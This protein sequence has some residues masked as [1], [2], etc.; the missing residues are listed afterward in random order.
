MV[1]HIGEFETEALL[2]RFIRDKPNV[3]FFRVPHE[4]Q[5]YFRTKKIDSFSNQIE[6]PSTRYKLLLTKIPDTISHPIVYG[7]IDMESSDYYDKRDTLQQNHNIKMKFYF[8]SQYR[9]Y[10]Y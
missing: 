4:G 8:R 1:A 9:K 6:V 3:L 5:R 10:E 2:V 7:Y